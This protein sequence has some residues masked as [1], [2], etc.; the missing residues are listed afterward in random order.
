MTWHIL[1]TKLLDNISSDTWCNQMT[2]AVII[3]TLT[4]YFL[5]SL[6]CILNIGNSMPSGALTAS[7]CIACYPIS[8]IHWSFECLDC[9]GKCISLTKTV[10]D[11]AQQWFIDMSM[12]R[13]KNYSWMANCSHVPLSQVKTRH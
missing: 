9:D 5:W 10:W 8:T 12:W 6:I 3:T 4:N 11:Q 2:L 1:L 7:I 13:W